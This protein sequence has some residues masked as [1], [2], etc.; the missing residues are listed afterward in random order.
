MCFLKLS[1]TFG[2]FSFGVFHRWASSSSNSSRERSARRWFFSE[3]CFQ[4]R[5]LSRWRICQTNAA[6]PFSGLTRAH[7]LYYRTAF[8]QT[9]S[10]GNWSRLQFIWHWLNLTPRFTT[11]SNFWNGAI[12]RRP[13]ECWWLNLQWPNW[14]E[15]WELEGPGDLPPG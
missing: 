14:S 4:R 12:G 9:L 6:L 7:W 8:K 11:W 13:T 3:N 2:V 10:Y 5:L 15:Y 1:L